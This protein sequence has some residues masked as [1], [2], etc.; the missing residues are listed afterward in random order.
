MFRRTMAAGLL[1]LASVVF[2][3]AAAV[4]IDFI[5]PTG[6]ISCAQYPASGPDTYNIGICRTDNR[7]WTYY[8][9][10]AGEFELESEDKQA[11]ILGMASWESVTVMNPNLDETPVFSGP[12]ETDVVFQEGVVPGFESFG[13]LTWCQDRTDGTTWECDQH[14]V[15]IRGA[16][17]YNR[18]FVAHE[19][20][21]ALGL[22]HGP[23]ANPPTS[24]TASIMGIMTTG[25]LPSSIGSTAAA[26][27]N[28][29]Y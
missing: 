14:Y 18:W 12:G 25:A 29:F 20:G 9:D 24:G 19:T 10:S 15:R 28:G 21:H 2:G 3:A 23:Q 8:M 27:V 11:A 5:V 7:N 4:A 17:I 1:A 16:G 26:Q 6:Y 13:G 22:T